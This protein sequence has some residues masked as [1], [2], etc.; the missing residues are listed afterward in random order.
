M[1]LVNLAG[2]KAKA[3]PNNWWRSALRDKLAASCR[4]RHLSFVVYLLFD[5]VFPIAETLCC[6]MQGTTVVNTLDLQSIGRAC[7]LNIARSCS[8]NCGKP[9]SWS[10]FKFNQSYG[11]SVPVS[12]SPVLS[13]PAAFYQP[14]TQKSNV[15]YKFICNYFF[16]SYRSRVFQLSV[17][18]YVTAIRSILPFYQPLQTLNRF[19]WLCYDL[20]FQRSPN[21]TQLLIFKLSALWN[22]T[23]I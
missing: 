8:L 11:P 7:I 12:Y 10:R 5:V 14:A 21:G 18:R 2:H 23:L 1:S 17:W 15:S 19:T 6:R 9:K 20:V 13:C 16:L 22:K 4:S 3:F